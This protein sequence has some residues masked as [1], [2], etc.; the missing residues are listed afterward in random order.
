MNTFVSLY[1][2]KDDEI[3]KFLKKFSGLDTIILETPLKWTKKYENPV[4]MADIIAAL[5]DNN[6][7]YN[8]NMW[9]SIDEGYFI[10][11]TKYNVNDIIK[12]LYE[13][14]PY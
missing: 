11:V 3:E 7:S 8:I 1:S 13:R 9:V 14:Y 10:N 6:D 4:E 5:V 2:I 12:Y